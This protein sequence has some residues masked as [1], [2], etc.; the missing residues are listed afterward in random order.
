MPDPVTHYCF[1]YRVSDGLDE[2]IR[3]HL[4]MPIF[5][6]AL[7]G[8]DPWATLAFY[9]GRRKQYACRGGLM[10][11][12]HTGDFLFALAREARETKSDAV[13]SV[14]AGAIC[15]YCLD[16]TAHP[17]IIC[18]GG[19]FDGS[20]ETRAFRGGHVR[21]ERAIDSY[22]IRQ[23]YGMTP[24]KFSIPQQIMKLKAYPEILRAPLDRVFQSVYGWEQVFDDLNVALRDERWFYGMM[25]DPVGILRCLLRLISGGDTNYSLYSYY[26][27]EIDFRQL[28]FLNQ[29]HGVWHHPFDP[30]QG[31]T[32]SFFDLMDRAYADA[33]TLIHRAHCFVY[34]VDCDAF[35]V[36]GMQGNL[37]ENSNYST[38]FLC[39]DPRNETAPA[40]EPLPFSEKF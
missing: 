6:R 14:L 2:K 1:G 34:D 36:L 26:R 23:T 25:Q 19:G 29:Q 3:I 8:P 40:Y 21:L 4:N 10:H 11:K 15:H 20:K 9:G 13:F 37:F 18:K 32:E 5:E 38:G 17:Y 16:R 22:F 27:R 33:K 31:S 35:N 12:M 7:Q 30:Q 28:D 24:W 39:E